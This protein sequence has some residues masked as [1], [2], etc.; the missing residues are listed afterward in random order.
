M[1]Q[2]PKVNDVYT[3][4]T[5]THGFFMNLYTYLTENN[6]PVPQWLAHAETAHS[7]DFLYHAGR[8]GN[9]LIS[10]FV[11]KFVDDEG[12]ITD[13]DLVRI[14]GFWYSVNAGNAARFWRV[15]TTEYNPIENYSMHETA[16]TAKTGTDTV[17]ISGKETEKNTGTQ[18]VS[19]ES[20]ATGSVY[21][22][23]SSATPAPADTSTGE[24]ES[25]RTDNLTRETE[26]TNRNNETEYDTTESTETTRTGNIG[27]LTTQA[28]LQSDLDLWAW[29]F[30]NDY[31]FRAVDNLL[32]VPLYR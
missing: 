24:T 31:L 27:T 5:T 18:S 3:A 29:N 19:G 8:S 26:Y 20:S 25:T 14:S 12:F 17:T 7:L 1:K 28:M 9:K 15:Y 32:T 10:R 16:E 21:G 23:N 6:L 13:S 2:R 30:Y 22:F 11:L 4:W